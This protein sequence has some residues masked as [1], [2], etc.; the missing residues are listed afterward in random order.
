ME[1]NNAKSSYTGWDSVAHIDELLTQES[2]QWTLCEW[3]EGN[4]TEPRPTVLRSTEAYPYLGIL[5]DAALTGAPERAKV[6]GIVEKRMEKIGQCG[7]SVTLAKLATEESVLGTVR[8]RA[9]TG[10]LRDQDL[11]K[12]SKTIASQLNRHGQFRDKMI[13][14]AT[15]LSQAFGGRGLKSAEEIGIRESVTNARLTLAESAPRLRML[16]AGI[17][18]E[19]R[20]RYGTS[21]HDSS[22]PNGDPSCD[23]PTSIRAQRIEGGGFTLK[24]QGESQQAASVEIPLA[25]IVRRMQVRTAQS[26]DQKKNKRSIGTRFLEPLWEIGIYTAEQLTTGTGADKCWKTEEELHEVTGGVAGARRA[27]RLVQWQLEIGRGTITPKSYQ[28]PASYDEHGDESRSLLRLERMEK[29]CKEGSGEASQEPEPSRLRKE[30][31]AGRKYNIV[32]QPGSNDGMNDPP[33]RAGRWTSIASESESASES[34]EQ[35]REARLRRREQREGTREASSVPAGARRR[36]IANQP[37]VPR[38]FTTW[39]VQRYG[40]GRAQWDTYYQHTD[41][42]VV[43]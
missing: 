15:F 5:I 34:Q 16:Y 26:A 41:R 31:S 4:A 3:A 30:D 2:Q 39:K 32:R 27:V 35:R 11:T 25:K 40:G 17:H 7:W 36:R 9:G 18:D 29:E 42:H 10:L 23:L 33:T 20:R 14:D 28:Q 24:R 12:I 13:Y 38:S 8:Y 6:Q 43:R 1:V 37:G 21:K 19:L 22:L